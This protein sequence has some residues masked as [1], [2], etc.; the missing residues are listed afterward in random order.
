MTF[1]I[2]YTFKDDTS[3]AKHVHHMFDTFQF[4]VN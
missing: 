1:Y 2:F 3:K 4:E